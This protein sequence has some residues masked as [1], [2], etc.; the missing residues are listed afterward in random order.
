VNN[1]AM[2]TLFSFSTTAVFLYDIMMSESDVL[3]T[4]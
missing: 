3:E 1:S 2:V 4:R